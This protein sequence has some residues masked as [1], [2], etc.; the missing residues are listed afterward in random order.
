VLETP[1]QLWLIIAMDE[2][3]EKGTEMDEGG[4]EGGR[5]GVRKDSY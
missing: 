1:E 2:G 4:R 3:T 5:E